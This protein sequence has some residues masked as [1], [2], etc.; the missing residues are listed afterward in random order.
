[1]STICEDLKTHDACQESIAAVAA[2]VGDLDAPMPCSWAWALAVFSAPGLPTR[3]YVGWGVGRLAAPA[4]C[5]I[6]PGAILIGADLTGARR[7]AN[8]PPIPGWRV[9]DGRLVR[10]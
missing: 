6:M 5:G 7:D 3:E 4:D 8:D 1:M 9:G 10:S 2:V